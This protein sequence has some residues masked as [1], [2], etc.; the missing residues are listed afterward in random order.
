MITDLLPGEL[1]RF[2]NDPRVLR[3]VSLEPVEEKAF[4]RVIVGAL[5]SDQH[6]RRAVFLASTK[7]LP[8]VS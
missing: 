8:A 3:F 6:H 7:V 4:I 5:G 2:E 1:F